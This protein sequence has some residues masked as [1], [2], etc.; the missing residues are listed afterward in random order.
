MERTP[1]FPVGWDPSPGKQFQAEVL[2]MFNSSVHHPSSSTNGCFFLLVVF[3]RFTFRL[4]EESV[5]L[6]LQSVLGG[7][8][9][10]FH[11]HFESDQHFR[12]SVASKA[13]GFHICS[14]KRIIAKH[15][16]VYFHLW[17]GGGAHW[18][19]EKKLWIEEEEKQ[20]TKVSRKKKP[21]KGNSKKVTFAHKLVQESPT[22][23]S[24]PA[25]PPPSIKI[26]DIICPLDV[27]MGKSS[28]GGSPSAPA[29]LIKSNTVFSG[30]KR[31]LG[32]CAQA[33]KQCFKCLDRGHV[34]RDCTGP[35]RCRICFGYN[36]LAKRCFNQKHIPRQR[37][38]PK[39]CSNMRQPD[40]HI[41]RAQGQHSDNSSPT[42][43]R[44]FEPLKIYASNRTRDKKEKYF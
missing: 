33:S 17:R 34:T 30:L 4:T 37:W 43:I 3:R 19:L 15:F 27:S 31:D 7:A 16:D 40:Q 25:F 23:K 14:L 8:A 24:T 44:S 2:K 5:S 36:H 41:D 22:R 29:I 6:A 18:Q 21:T 38:V 42:A 1:S 26:G 39:A 10:G 35:F 20:W 13:V 28:F 9:A 11:V 12:F 32:I